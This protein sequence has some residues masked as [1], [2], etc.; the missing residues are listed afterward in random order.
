MLCSTEKWGILESLVLALFTL[1]IGG[2]GALQNDTTVQ[3]I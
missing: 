2:N 3:P 1:C